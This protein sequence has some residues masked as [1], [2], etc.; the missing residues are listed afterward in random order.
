[1]LDTGFLERILVLDLVLAGRVED[2]FLDHGMNHQLGCWTSNLLFLVARLVGLLEEAL[3]LRWSL[4]SGV[5]RL[6]EAEALERFPAADFASACSPPVQQRAAAASDGT[7][8]V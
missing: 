2:L 6:E 3:D 5:S 4:A 7:D 1:M 8:A